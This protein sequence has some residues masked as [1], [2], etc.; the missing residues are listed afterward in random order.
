MI[1]GRAGARSPLLVAC[2]C[3]AILSPTCASPPPTPT[4]PPDFARILPLARDGVGLATRRASVAGEDSGREMLLTKRDGVHSWASSYEQLVADL[5]RAI[6]EI[7]P[8]RA[9]DVRELYQTLE[10]ADAATIAL[11]SSLPALMATRFDVLS[12]GARFLTAVEEL[13]ALA[14]RGVADSEIGA[15]LEEYSQVIASYNDWQSPLSELVG[16]IN[17]D[18]VVLLLCSRGGAEVAAAVQ[19]EIRRCR[20]EASCPHRYSG[21]LNRL[22]AYLRTDQEGER[23]E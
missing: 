2:L 11:V 23:A 12:R 22:V 1:R 5:R 16:E 15:F 13:L 4:V 6:P 14:E 9:Y 18:A 21:W 8:G 3:A 20:D 17:G 7:E 19:Q 10:A